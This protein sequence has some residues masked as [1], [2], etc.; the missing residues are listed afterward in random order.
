MDFHKAVPVV[1][2]ENVVHCSA[3]SLFGDTVSAHR[4]VIHMLNASTLP[5]D[6][7]LCSSKSRAGMLEVL[8]SEFRNAFAGIEYQVDT[9][10]RIVNA[11]AFR[12]GSSRFIRIYGGFALHP[13][14]NADALV[15]TLLHEMGHH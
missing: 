5:G 13:L 15:F 9:Q 11:Q 2:A 10:T 1:V 3:R 12:L 6:V 4:Q 14:V 8:L 7:T